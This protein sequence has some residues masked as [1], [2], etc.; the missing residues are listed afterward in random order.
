MKS[1]IA[2]IIRR[3]YLTR[4]KK[5]SFIIMTILGPILFA[6]LLV[7]PMLLMN[8]T[9]DSHK[10]VVVDESNIFENQLE[11]R[12]NLVFSRVENIDDAKDQL[13]NGTF[14]LLLHIQKADENQP[15]PVALFYNRQQPG[16]GTHSAIENQLQD[17]F[18]NKLLME[19]FH[20]SAEE[21]NAI[22]AIRINVRAQN[23]RTGEEFAT[24]LN[25]GIGYFTAFLIYLFVFLFGAQVMQGVI[26]EKSNRIVE[27]IVSSVKPFQIMM[28]KIVGIAMVG[29]TQFF[30]W[31]VL[32]VGI[33]T[34]A[35]I[36]M[37]PTLAQAET[38]QMATD[39]EAMVPS[40]V[41]AGAAAMF[42][43]IL[44]GAGNI[45][46]V[47]IILM[48]LIYFI[49]GYLLYASLFAAV[50][51]AV[52]NEADTQQFMLPI[53]VPLIIA[54]I[55][56][57]MIMQDP[58]GTVAFWLSMVPLTSPVVMMMRVPFGVPIWELTLSIGLLITGFVF[59]TW[60]AAKIYRVGILMYGKKVSYKELW[61]WLRY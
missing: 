8:I 47:F 10:I 44:A 58:N 7:V 12:G 3:E 2:L 15:N 22:R 31:I 35:G 39:I 9:T 16:L 19:T 18:R 11:D 57:P 5:K 6:S 53:T 36:V 30:L 40:E 4:V 56:I 42:E 1:K 26:E 55:A 48:F 50:G 54:I 38:S 46:F 52:D 60:L 21:Y 24:G 17:I 45:D 33:V 20:I 41:T 28:G 27:V 59:T 51:S 37:A 32:T 25:T 61:K 34:V 23:V 49:G 29:L 43:N 14:D 13:K